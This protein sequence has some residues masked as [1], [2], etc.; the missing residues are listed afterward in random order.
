MQFMIEYGYIVLFLFIFLD[1]IGLP[2]PSMPVILGA[3]ALAGTGDMNAYLVILVAVIACVPAD[4]CWY[5]L[6]RSRGGKVLTIIC[7]ISLEP[8]YCIRRTELSFEKLGAFSLVVAK[9]VPGLQTIAPPMA[10]LTQMP[11]MRF[12]GL[13]ILGA[14]LWACVLTWVGYLFSHQL[15]EIVT[16]FADLGGLA[17]S[18]VVGAFAL[19]IV[20]K[21][22]QRR[23]FLS[24]LRTRMIDPA[25]VNR[26]VANDESVYIIDLRHRLDF[27]AL[28]YTV[29]NAVRVPM[30]SIEEHHDL[31]PRDKDIV[32]YCS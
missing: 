27:N 23:L 20:V 16:R 13:D 6:G 10:G 19:F 7:S 18:L 2:L 25:E 1:Q 12:L 26:L 32:L 24:S 4:F 30:E 28:P 31:I 17:A 8:D 9:F 29:P 3:G 21:M 15:T 5:Y 11:T 22:V 14:L